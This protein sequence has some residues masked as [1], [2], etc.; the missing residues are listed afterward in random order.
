MAADQPASAVP[1]ENIPRSATRRSAENG[2]DSRPLSAWAELGAFVLL[3]EPGGGKSC[4]F[5]FEADASGGIC[6]KAR[7]FATLGPPKGWC[8]ETGSDPYYG[9][10]EV[11]CFEPGRG[12]VSLTVDG[13]AGPS[14]ETYTLT[15]VR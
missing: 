4:A 10:R 13:R 15:R 3:A 9:A 6:V 8:G 7:E 1:R 5:R 2:A 12:L 14:E 11:A